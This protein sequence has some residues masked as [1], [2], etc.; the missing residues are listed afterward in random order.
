MK[1]K[2]ISSWTQ[3][4][5]N[6]R[7]NVYRLKNFDYMDMYFR[8]KLN[9]NIYSFHGVP[10]HIKNE[11]H[12]SEFVT[13]I[14]FNFLNFPSS[15]L[16]PKTYY[17]SL[18]KLKSM[19]IEY[20]LFLQDDCW[21]HP[22]I[23]KENCDDLFYLIKNTKFNIINLEMK[24]S[25]ISNSSTELLATKGDIKMY[26]TDTSKTLWGDFPYIAN[27][28]FLLNEVYDETYFNGKNIWEA[29]YNLSHRIKN[30]KVIEMYT[31][32][33]P[34]YS[35]I[36]ICGQS[37][38]EHFP[39]NLKLLTDLYIHKNKKFHFQKDYFSENSKFLK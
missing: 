13:N 10:E 26:K 4:H 29:E 8:K 24:S 15:M 3:T 11:I 9:N 33:I 31:L 19:G 12:N 16:Y 17:K 1:L 39:K 30:S 6:E 23:T 14:K 2:T 27:I 21:M 22:H 20:I 34:F 25:R 32:N 7:Q 38:R 35:R 18:L 36:G 5:G 28:N 37:G